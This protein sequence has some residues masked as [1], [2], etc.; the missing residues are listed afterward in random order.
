[1]DRMN[2]LIITKYIIPRRQ[3]TA[4]LWVYIFN[5]TQF[6]SVYR[7]KTVKRAKSTTFQLGQWSIPSP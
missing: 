7:L 5:G 4:A 3:A 1:M 6:V 2:R